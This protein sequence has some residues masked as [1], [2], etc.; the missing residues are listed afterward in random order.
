MQKKKDMATCNVTS[1]LF[2]ALKFIILC[3]AGPLLLVRPVSKWE[4]HDKWDK[5]NCRK[6]I[7]I[8]TYGILCTRGFFAG[9]KAAGT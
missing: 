2:E 5:Q 6:Q 9:G 3:S 1:L 4:H 7:K 8:S